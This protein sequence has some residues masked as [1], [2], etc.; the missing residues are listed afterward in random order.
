MPW[1]QRRTN[2]NEAAES[3]K[4][5]DSQESKIEKAET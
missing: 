2:Q 1:G 4:V 3:E 5:Q